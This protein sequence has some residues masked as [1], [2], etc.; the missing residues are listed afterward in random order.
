MLLRQPQNDP[1]VVAAA[2]VNAEESVADTAAALEGARAI[3]TE[4]FDEDADLKGAL[5]EEMW[6]NGR[7]GFSVRTG[8]QAGEKFKDYFDFS[9][10]LHKLPSHRILAMF[11][12]EKEG[13]LD[14]QI[15]PEAQPPAPGVSS[16]YELKIM[17]RFGSSQ[18]GRPGDNWLAETVR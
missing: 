10:P 9:E 7:M 4:R 6:S 1:L 12:G 3:L 14:L 17:N 16:S 5:R 18:Q 15:Q 13:I 2:F 8:K 11:R